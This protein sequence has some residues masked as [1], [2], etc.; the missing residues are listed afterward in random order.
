MR[1][2]ILLAARLAAAERWQS[3]LER[4]T[5]PYR[6]DNLAVDYWS[7][8]DVRQ[9]ALNRGQSTMAGVRWQPGHSVSGLTIDFNDGAKAVVTAHEGPG[10]LRKRMAT[11]LEVEDSTEGLTLRPQLVLTHGDIPLDEPNASPGNLTLFAMVMEAL[12][13]ASRRNSIAR[14]LVPADA[15][16]LDTLHS[17]GFQRAPEPGHAAL[18]LS[19]QTPVTT[20]AQ[21]WIT[22]RGLAV[23]AAVWPAGSGE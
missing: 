5:R 14:V 11:A 3:L 12:V 6:L 20:F 10:D 21:A 13:I 7:E 18:I 15:D 8:M 4:P 19:G 9:Y 22:Y 17:W 1:D 2:W 16:A 23:L